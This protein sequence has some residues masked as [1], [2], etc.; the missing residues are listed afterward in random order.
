[1]LNDAGTLSQLDNALAVFLANGRVFC[2]T[3]FWKQITAPLQV[4][5]FNA[6]YPE[7]P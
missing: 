2:F 7:F 1:M 5:S 4:V 6:A 3:Q